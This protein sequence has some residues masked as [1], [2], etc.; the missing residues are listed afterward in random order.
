MKPLSHDE[1]ALIE[2]VGTAPVLDR[3]L[4]W[5]SVNSGTAN[6]DGV[7]VMAERLGDAFSEL[8]GDVSLV[9][10]EPVDKVAPDGST[11]P[12][13]HGRHL[14]VRVRPDADRRVLLTGHMD[15]VFPKDH[16]F[17][18]SQWIDEDTLNG[19]GT[20]DMKG[21]LSLMLEGLLAF[22]RT[23]PALGYDVM[24]NSD[25]ETGSK[26]SASLIADLAKGKLAALTYEP[27]LPGGIMARAR[28]G[29]GNFAAI[30]HGKSAHAGRNPEEGRNALV[31][32]SDLA[33]RLFA[34]RRDGLSV[35]PARI[36]GGA[37]NNTVPDLAVLHFNMR[38]RTP[39]DEA[40]AH[41]IIDDAVT[42]VSEAHDV[43]IDLHG[44]F[45]R[46]PKP[47]SAQADRLFALVRE[48]A[49]DLG[50]PMEWKDT[51][52]V[53]DGNNIAACGV[54]VLDTMGACGG[55]IHSPDEFMLKSSLAPRARLTA[56][57]LHRLERQ[58]L[59]A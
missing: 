8:P 26:S 51:G 45:G 33:Q 50:E 35:N 23:S 4:D 6:L 7:A 59:A 38:P 49:A 44:N 17:Q 2:P 20:A 32:A 47:I 3:T 55:L 34:A 24:I 42:A 14:V 43:G 40:E 28:P 5:A 58:G 1:A 46:P 13:R 16:V 29:S 53:C 37:V 10:P 39:G 48:A 25:E 31:A 52:G 11:V 15:T 22:E 54:P 19:P 9:D 56:L 12:I 41:A 21:G 18:S 36:E 30:V 27:A 57:V